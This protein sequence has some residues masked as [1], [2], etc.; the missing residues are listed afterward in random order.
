[1]P[2][3]SLLDLRSQVTF[4]LLCAAGIAIAGFAFGQRGGDDVT[5][6]PFAAEDTF[7]QP[8]AETE[9]NVVGGATTD[10]LDGPNFL[11]DR[12]PD[13]ATTQTIEVSGSAWGG[14]RVYS[15]LDAAIH[16]P[17]G[18]WTVPVVLVP[19]ENQIVIEGLGEN[20][21]IATE[22]FTVTYEPGDLPDVAFSAQQEF[23]ASQEP[24]PWE[25]F[26]GTATPLSTIIVSSEFG[27][28]SAVSDENGAWSTAVFF[29]APGSNEPFPVGVEAVNGSVTF[30]FTYTPVN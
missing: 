22:T 9:P 8:V 29:D 15:S 1:M 14:T 13:F 26:S 3:P 16:T 6:L 30:D 11:V 5:S 10:R 25:F 2:R 7:E 17:E 19:G 23:L 4:L 18:E 27:T 28:A 24:E 12:I 20:G 21:E